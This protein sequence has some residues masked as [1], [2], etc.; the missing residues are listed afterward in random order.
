MRETAPV[1]VDR[2][3]PTRTIAL[4]RLRF[5]ND[6][7][8]SWLQGVLDN[9]PS[10][11]PLSAI[12]GRVQGTLTSLGREIATASGPIDNLF[13]SSDGYVVLVETKLWRNPD[14]RRSVVAQILDY[15]AQIRRWDYTQLEAL[16]K[17]RHGAA[18]MWTGLAPEEP[19]QDWVDRV[20]RNLSEGRLTLLV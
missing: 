1:L 10:L 3:D 13:L 8:E 18:N 9:T 7:S 12:D 16:W 17:R 15:A 19:E 5:E 6:I 14:A 20:S 4:T 11:L 2:E